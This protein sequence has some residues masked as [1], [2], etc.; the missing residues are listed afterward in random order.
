MSTR[1]QQA[2]LLNSIKVK[3]EGL[4]IVGHRTSVA[5]ALVAN[6][7]VPGFD[8]PATTEILPLL[9]FRPLQ[10]RMFQSSFYEGSELDNK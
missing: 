4:E 5:R 8:S 2:V 9:L 6:A 10:V 7:R 3:C 1:L